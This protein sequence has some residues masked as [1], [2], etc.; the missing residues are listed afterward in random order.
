M[1]ATSV[2]MFTV[3]DFSGPNGKSYKPAIG[4]IAADGLT[5]GGPAKHPSCGGRSLFGDIALNETTGR[6][7]ACGSG[8]TLSGGTMDFFDPDGS[9]PIASIPLDSLTLNSNKAFAMVYD[10]T[11][12]AVVQTVVWE[13]TSGGEFAND[14]ATTPDGG[15]VVVGSTRGSMP[16]FTN[17]APGTPDGYVEKYNAAGT[18][19]WSY[20]T[21]TAATD[22]FRTVTVDPDGAVYVTGT[23][24]A[25][26]PLSILSC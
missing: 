13:S 14:I 10:T 9:G 5:F 22:S 1:P 25:T 19:V 21:Q 7:Y 24:G 8:S 3:G 26:Q 15:F 20:Q 6:V 17:P 18:L 2:D 4:W 11:T 23:T 16:G 12:W